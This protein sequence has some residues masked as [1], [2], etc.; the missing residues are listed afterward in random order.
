MKPNP[1][2]GDLLKML[3]GIV[4]AENPPTAGDFHPVTWW[5]REWGMHPSKAREL[6]AKGLQAGVVEHRDAYIQTIVG[7]R[8]APHYKIN[9]PLTQ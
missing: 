1:S 4:A 7:R 5:A 9:Q 3:K 6:I 2:T 8:K